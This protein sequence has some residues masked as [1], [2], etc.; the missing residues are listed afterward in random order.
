MKTRIREPTV[1]HRSTL[2]VGEPRP[3]GRT[4]PY[5]LAFSLTA[6]FLA[7]FGFRIPEWS[8]FNPVQERPPIP[9][10]FRCL[11]L[12]CPTTPLRFGGL[13]GLVL[14]ITSWPKRLARLPTDNIGFGSTPSATRCLPP[15]VF[16]I[17]PLCWKKAPTKSTLWISGPTLVCHSIKLGIFPDR[18]DRLK[19]HPD[20]S[21][22]TSPHV[23]STTETIGHKS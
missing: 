23:K 21:C 2:A 15:T 14:M 1:G 18:S 4:V 5:P 13:P 6:V 8:P 16:L 3:C 17:G 22:R 19:T 9:F 11:V 12:L 20:G 10:Q 7:L